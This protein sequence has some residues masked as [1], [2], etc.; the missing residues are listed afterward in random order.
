MGMRRSNWRSEPNF[1]AWSFMVNRIFQFG[2]PNDGIVG[3]SSCLIPNQAVAGTPTSVYFVG[4]MGHGDL[5]GSSKNGAF[6]TEK[7]MKWVKFVAAG[8][9]SMC[10]GTSSKLFTSVGLEKGF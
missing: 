10:R 3:L 1:A 5:T 6:E 2:E 9:T 4:N 7:P 8:W